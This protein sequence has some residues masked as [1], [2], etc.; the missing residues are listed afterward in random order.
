[1]LS[2]PSVNF[3]SS[4]SFPLDAN[5][6]KGQSSPARSQP[7]AVPDKSVTKTPPTP[8][9]SP[10]SRERTAAL[11]RAACYG[12]E[13]ANAKAAAE[14]QRA[15]EAAANSAEKNAKE[16]KAAPATPRGRW[17]ID[18]SKPRIMVMKMVDSACLPIG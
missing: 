3:F 4:S 9:S 10:L 5:A 13:R 7:A 17:G 14:R 2:G 8:E 1:M 16:T 15:S 18:L 12:M 6:L 11:N